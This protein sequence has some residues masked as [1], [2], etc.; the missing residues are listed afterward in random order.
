VC[1]WIACHGSC[2]QLLSNSMLSLAVH[3]IEAR[4][5][6]LLPEPGP[7]SSDSR[8]TS[9]RAA[10]AR[11]KPA[12]ACRYPKE[13]QGCVGDSPYR[14]ARVQVKIG[15]SGGSQIPA[16]MARAGAGAGASPTPGPGPGPGPE[17]ARPQVL[18]RTPPRAAGPGPVSG[19]HGRQRG[20]PGHG[21]TQASSGRARCTHAARK[22]YTETHR[23]PRRAAG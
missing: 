20:G 8:A 22:S 2:V 14:Q 13:A 7:R 4:P 10:L 11:K 16:R 9:L 15:G 5:R 19:N 18:A 12:A 17:P 6:S 1:R 3:G 23:K 21:G